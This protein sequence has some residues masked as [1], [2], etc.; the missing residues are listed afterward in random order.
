MAWG[1]VNVFGCHTLGP[2]EDPDAAQ[3]EDTRGPE[4]RTTRHTGGQGR[5]QGGGCLIPAITGGQGGG[6]LIPAITGV[7]VEGA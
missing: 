2:G 6:C 5:G 7:R 1:W 4:A 3:A